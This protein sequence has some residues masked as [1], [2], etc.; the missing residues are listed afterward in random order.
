[1]PVL[2]KVANTQNPRQ[3]VVPP[4]VW[5]QVWHADRLATPFLSRLWMQAGQASG[6]YRDISR[7]YQFDGGR[8]VLPLAAVSRRFRRER[9]MSMPYGMGAGG[10]I[11]D[12]EPGRAEMALIL[13]DLAQ[14][15]MA[16]VAIRPNPLTN[17]CWQVA[18]ERGW[19]PV[20]RI[21]HVL[22]LSA[23]YESVWKGM[24]GAK[25]NKIRKAR[26]VGLHVERGN[27]ADLIDQ[28]YEIYLQ[29][30][31]ARAQRRN[32]PKA[33]ITLLARWREP[34]WKFDAAATHMASD[35]SVLVASHEGR[36]VAG[37][38]YL[39]MGRSA[40]YWRG[41]SDPDLARQFPAN[42]LLQ[43]EM[44]GTA[45]AAGC[46]HYH[47]GESGGVESLMRFKSQFG[48]QP[49]SYTEWVLER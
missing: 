42:D 6:H 37:A 12:F 1:M 47:M 43:D 46:T 27:S 38:I 41:A 22:D 35:L 40:V 34:R 24:D 19:T 32:L 3:G 16:H 10:L 11:A 4:A 21:S 9:A 20:E 7:Y 2:D 15:G 5:D 29:W 33:L 36:P 44:I 26:S 17:A 13:D 14:L 48:A 39:Q 45:C 25:R 30:S 28:F 18:G 49:I 8:A 23:G 31:A